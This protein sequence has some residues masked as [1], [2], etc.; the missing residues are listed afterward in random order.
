MTFGPH[1]LEG[2]VS[3]KIVTSKIL[4]GWSLAIPVRRR[5]QVVMG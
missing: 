1:G 2:H 5:K 4:P 3:L